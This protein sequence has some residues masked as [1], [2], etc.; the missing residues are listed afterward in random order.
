MLVCNTF[1]IHDLFHSHNIP[2][3]SV[4]GRYKQFSLLSTTITLDTTGP[5]LH[6]TIQIPTIK[7]CQPCTYQNQTQ[8]F[9]HNHVHSSLRKL[10]LSHLTRSCNCT[11]LELDYIAQA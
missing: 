11:R 7:L 2:Q 4:T 6:A 8:R 5:I 3:A 10:I 9:Y 1:S